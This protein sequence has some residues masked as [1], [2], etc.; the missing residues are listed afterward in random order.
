MTRKFNFRELNQNMTG[1]KK[2]KQE[3]KTYEERKNNFETISCAER[4]D[5]KFIC[6]FV[7][8]VGMTIIQFLE[9]L[10]YA[11]YNDGRIERTN[12]YLYLA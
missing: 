9:Q 6:N 2:T 8:I 12:T 11:F 1:T 3:L 5:E 4:L 10:K 7:P